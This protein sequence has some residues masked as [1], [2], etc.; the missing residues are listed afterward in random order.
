[1]RFIAH[2]GNTTG[3]NP[4]SENNPDYIH[5]VLTKGYDVE[6]DLWYK[7]FNG[8]FFGH[9]SAQYAVTDADWK[10]FERYKDKMWLHAKNA[11]A[12]EAA[13][14]GAGM[15]GYHVFWHQNDDFTITNTG[16][17]WTYPGKPL[18]QNAV[19][20]LPETAPAF[21]I[22]EAEIKEYYGYGICSD[23]IRNIRVIREG[24]I[25]ISK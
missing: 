10:D 1:M 19:W 25:R 21:S 11:D 17:V 6:V 14:F 23:Y 4:H 5:D 3:P 18:M 16:Q 12:L 2:R 24:E 22:G 8:F 15:K 7:P 9:D 13:L 20:V